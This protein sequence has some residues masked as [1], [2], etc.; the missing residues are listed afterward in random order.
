LDD[1]QARMGYDE[2]MVIDA[3]VVL[4]RCPYWTRGP[5]ISGGGTAAL[6][7]ARSYPETALAEV[8]ARAR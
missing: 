6:A 5:P 4:T 7:E 8:T 3:A 2:R 1:D